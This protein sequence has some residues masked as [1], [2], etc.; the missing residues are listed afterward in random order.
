M[1]YF[2]NN[3]VGKWEKG[4]VLKQKLKTLKNLQKGT[5]FF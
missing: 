4:M 3:F 2:L 5:V 1:F